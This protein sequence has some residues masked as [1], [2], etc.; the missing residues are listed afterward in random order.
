MGP[1]YGKHNDAAISRA[2]LDKCTE[3]SVLCKDNDTHIVDRGF[4]DVVEE[5]QAL[6]YDLKMPGLLS[7]GDKQLSTIDANESRLITKCRWVVESFHARFK[8][9]RFFSEQIDQ[10]F[11]LNLGT[12]SRIIAASLNR[13][14]PIIYDTTSVE[15]EDMA[16]RML[17]LLKQQSNIETLVSSGQLSLRKNGIKLFELRENF[18]FPHLDLDFLRNYTCG[19]Y[20]LKMSEPY[21][22]AHLYEN[23][24]EFE[25]QMSPDNDQLIRCRLHS[26]HSGNTRYFICI[27][28][29]NK[30]EDEPIKDH[31]C[32]C[33]GGKRKI[34]CCA[35][36]A[37][38]LWYIG[39]ARHIGWTPKTRTDQF[40]EKIM[41]C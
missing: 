21:A 30:D 31:F 23:E 10:S 3:L 12:L 6:G 14:R 38:I 37:T 2:I 11:L 17:S 41:T 9:W 28:F 18:N 1:F 15:H 22:K 33:K 34:G 25:L 27:E 29:D 20:Q 19:T 8:K 24:N 26:R 7:K 4:R 13:Y 35:H 5:F 32:Q 36:I 39:Y 16:Q 40:K